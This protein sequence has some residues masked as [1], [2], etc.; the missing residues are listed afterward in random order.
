LIYRRKGEE[1]KKKSG[2]GGKRK[3][4]RKRGYFQEKGGTAD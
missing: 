4:K 3:P 1:Y 2:E